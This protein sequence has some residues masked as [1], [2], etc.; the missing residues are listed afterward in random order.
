M[1]TLQSLYPTIVDWRRHLHMHP[2]LSFEEVNTPA[3]IADKLE[4]LGLEVTRNVGG[5][6]VVAKL[7]GASAGPTLALRAD[8][9]ALPIDEENATT[10]RSK[11][12]GVMHACGHD[13]HT[14]AL[15][16]VATVL[17]DQKEEL[18]G[19]LVFI[20]QHAEELPPGGAIE[21]IQDGCLEDVDVIYG[22][23]IASEMPLGTV[24]VRSGPVMAAVDR[25][26]IHLQG[27]GGHGA[28]PQTTV[29][30]IVAGS[31]LVTDL[32]QIVARRVDPMDNAVVTV[33]VFQAGKAFNVI[34]DSAVIEGTVRT[35]KPETRT[36]IEE[37]IRAIIQGT[38]AST[39]VSCTVDY[40]NGYPTLVNHE[41]ET[42]LVGSIAKE[43][44]GETSVIS[45]PPILGGEDFAYY[46][47]HKPGNFFHVGS[48]TDEE[49]TQYPHHHPRFDFDE[50]VLERIGEMFLQLVSH[51]LRK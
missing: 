39:H 21:M 10:Y 3:W 46:L 13:G 5:R 37:E 4:E 11:T 8:F 25:F 2:E 26:K 28:K 1:T 34:A 30:S 40:I 20:F 9:D 32:Q 35:F 38:E 51:Y 42:A 22:A 31:K 23:H 15:L 6:G 44:F 50:R 17:A 41:S 36:A 14:A 27:R 7:Y 45:G 29:D 18:S 33:G 43:L 47:E 16:G 24:N 48:R 19:T 12:L 49:Y